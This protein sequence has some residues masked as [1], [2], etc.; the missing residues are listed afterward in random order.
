MVELALSE[1]LLGPVALCLL[2]IPVLRQ[3]LTLLGVLATLILPGAL[4]SKVPCFSTE[5]TGPWPHLIGTGWSGALTILLGTLG[6]L[7]L[8]IVLRALL[9]LLLVLG[10]RLEL[11]AVW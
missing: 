1:V 4:T 11:I 5:E 9:E 3:L 8:L 2:R 6:A 7:L 10:S